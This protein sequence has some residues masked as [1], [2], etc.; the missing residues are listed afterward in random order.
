MVTVDIEAEGTAAYMGWV[1][2]KVGTGDTADVANSVG[3]SCT[4]D[5]GSIRPEDIGSKYSAWFYK[6]CKRRCFL[7]QI[8]NTALMCWRVEEFI[9][10]SVPVPFGFERISNTLEELCCMMFHHQKT[11]NRAS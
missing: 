5:Q 3:C 7:N 4:Y 9:L 8:V 10:A 11:H 1:A 2:G 6:A